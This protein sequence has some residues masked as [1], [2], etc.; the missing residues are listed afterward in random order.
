MGLMNKKE[1]KSCKRG[2]VWVSAIL[3]TLI[4]IAAMIL[5][6]KIGVPILEKIKDR[7]SFS[8]AKT[9]M[10]SIDKTINEV[11]N[12]GEGSQRIIPI[13][14]K[15][16]KISIKNNEITYELKT[17]TNV[18]ESRSDQ[19]F[20]N[21]KISS[22]SNV[23]TFETN[24]SYI[25]QTSIDGDIFNVSIKKIGSENNFSNINTNNLIESIWYNGEKLNGTFTFTLNEDSNT[26]TGNGYTIMN[27]QGNNI[28]L[29]KASV[30]AHIN[31]SNNAGEY[32][33]EFT[34]ESFADFLSVEIKDINS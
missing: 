25:M 20:G 10:L 27:P 12:E 13:D 14:V 32:E 7:S 23:K 2:E 33:L 24:L 17:K 1:V 5:I 15:D 34:L 16:G 8:N 28:N 18:M 6:L 31:S 9:T 26:E 11:A 22:N 21:L 29:G 3:Y 19:N 4:I 30:I